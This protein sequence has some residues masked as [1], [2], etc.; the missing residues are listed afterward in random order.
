MTTP[1]L[2]IAI[3]SIIAFGLFFLRGKPRLSITISMVL[4]LLLGFLALFQNFGEVVKIGA[5]SVDIGTTL[6]VFGRNLVLLNSDRYFLFLS[7]I[8]IL[9][10]IGGIRYLQ[11]RV[12]IIPYLMVILASLTAAIAVETFLYSSI[13]VEIAVLFSLPILIH[14][15]KPLSKGVLRFLL[16]QS[17]AMPM[18][19]IGGWFISGTQ[20]SPSDLQQLGVAGFFL[21]TGF[22]FWLAVFPFHSWVPLLSEDV[23]PHIFSFL[24]ALIPQAVLFLILDFS[25]SISWI[26]ES[27][28]FYTIL[29]L[30]GLIMVVTT[31]IWGLFEKK[32]KRYIAYIILFE[33]GSLLML[34]GLQTNATSLAYYFSMFP[35]LISI[36]LIGF[37]LSVINTTD[38]QSMKEITGVGRA[39][40]FASLGLIIAL[41]SLVGLPLLGEFPYKYILLSSIGEFRP[42]L[43]PWVFVGMTLVIIPVFILLSRIFSRI[44]QKVKIQESIPQILIICSGDFLLLLTGIYPK[45]LELMF[46]Q[47]IKYL[48]LTGV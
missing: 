31:G 30:T 23:H 12:N 27:D 39:Y 42:L 19:L 24:L 29:F 43:M 9:L 25:N 38:N 45:I 15:K 18:I 37:C 1:V 47:L 5:V 46:S 36:L 34:S 41:F 16:F 2:F 7:C 22:A 48:P 44:N 35:R 13:F 28:Q 26:R 33:T 11:L 32:L 10:T 4:Y 21:A 8:S 17:L 6:I 40:P 3:P 20:S 14:A